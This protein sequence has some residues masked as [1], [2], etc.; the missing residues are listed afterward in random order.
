MKKDDRYVKA[1]IELKKMVDDNAFG[2]IQF[3][4]QD[5]VLINFKKELTG[6]FIDEPVKQE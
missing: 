2:S 4:F 3:N 6:K 1:V 5:G